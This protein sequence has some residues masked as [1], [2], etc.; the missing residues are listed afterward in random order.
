MNDMNISKV[1]YLLMGKDYHN[2]QIPLRYFVD[3]KIALEYLKNYEKTNE[4]VVED[5]GIEHKINYEL[6]IIP[7]IETFEYKSI[8]SCENCVYYSPPCWDNYY[9][10]DCLKRYYIQADDDLRI[11]IIF[12]K[13]WVER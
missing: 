3:E 12:C 2:L 6:M 11:D 9:K 5:Y 7:F 4:L 8:K 13:D 1:G 10:H